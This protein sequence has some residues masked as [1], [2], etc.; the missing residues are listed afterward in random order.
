MRPAA[1]GS[2]MVD[3]ESPI[4]PPVS[5]SQLERKAFP[6][7]RLILLTLMRALGSLQSSIE[8]GD[9]QAIFRDS[10]RRVNANLCEALLGMRPE[11]VD[12]KLEA[13]VIWS[14]AWPVEDDATPAK[15]AF[16]GRAFE[17]IDAIG[18]ALR[19]GDEP[20]RRQLVGLVVRLSGEDPVNGP[21]GSLHVTL[22][23]EGAN[24]PSHVG[25]V[26]TS[27]QY[28]QA[29]DAHRDG[30]RLMV[31][32]VMERFERRKWMLWD[33]SDFSVVMN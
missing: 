10:D 30:R 29:C 11:I 8:S 24:A 9:A 31:T 2:F 20:Q 26:L 21:I 32:G 14:P 27:E 5:P 33:I 28:R 4:I 6:S 22:R 19:M 25:L 17:R 16:E 7:E 15:V 18:H 13:S 3:V 12:A 1:I 23:P